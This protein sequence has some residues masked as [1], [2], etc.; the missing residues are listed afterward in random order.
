M[1]GAGVKIGV[2]L[3]M[4]DLETGRPFGLAE[5]AG[6]AQQAEAL[7]Y[8][9]VWVMDHF[10]LENV[11]RRTGG[12]DPLIT[13]AHIAA[14]TRRVGLG[15]LVVCNSFRNPGQLAR[16][17]AALA[18]AANGR[19]IL[20]LGCGWEESEHAA[21]D[22]PFR[23]RVDRLEQTLDVLPRLLQGWRG[24][25]EGSQVH[26]HDANVLT[27]GEPPP[28]WLAAFG[29]RL[30][31]LTARFAEGWNSSWHGPDTTRFQLEV[32]ALRD[33]LQT[34]RRSLV[35]FTISAGLWVLPVSG[36]DLAFAEN[37]AESLKRADADESW[38]SP[39]R[40]RMSTGQVPEVAL[41]VE[42]YVALGARHIILNLSVT[43]FSLF[44]PSYMERAA[45]D[46][47]AVRELRS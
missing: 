20:G 38:P 37:R 7:G 22:F 34:S 26:L 17:V 18:D 13:L 32:T 33:G 12:H 40:E 10:W 39:V 24:N 44:D 14:C 21:F 5:M 27:T 46:A 36:R 3:Q 23:R 25:Y 41:T 8:D 4:F 15:T 16:E 47:V 35:D 29:P 31:G 11:G 6:H 43:P 19:L 2:A 42:K 28:I 45:P 9:S 30:L 1:N